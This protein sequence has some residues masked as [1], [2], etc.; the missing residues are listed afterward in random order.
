MSST[1]AV[2][3]ER[4]R[5]INPHSNA[6][7]LEI[8]T[9]LDWQCVVAKGAFKANDLCVYFPV[10]SILPAALE[11]HIFGPESKIRLTNS[12]IKTIKLRGQISQGLCV[13]VDEIHKYAWPCTNVHI[14]SSENWME[15]TD[16]TDIL[17]VTKYEPPAAPWSSMGDSSK[18]ARPKKN[19]LFAK[20]TDIE[21]AKNYP[22]M[23]KEGE[24][25]SVSEKCHGGNIR[26]AWAPVVAQTFLQ[27]LLKFFH[28]LPQY[29][30]VFGSHNVQLQSKNYTEK[31]IY[32]EMVKKYNLK[33]I[34]PKG[35]AVYG[36]VIGSG[37]QKNYTY[38]CKEGE[39]KLVLFDILCYN[40]KAHYLNPKK[41]KIL[42][43]QL[44]LETVPILYEGPFNKDKIKE[45][46]KGD[47][48]YAPSQKIREGVVVKPLEESTY[49]GSR[50]I[51]KFISDDYLLK[52]QSE[53][54]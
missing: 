49:L 41:F 27:K 22:E 12:R 18:S 48:V 8:A 50:K 9:I 40:G 36:E 28:L 13:P 11:E 45:L 26:M 20:Y 16:L 32:A 43:D 35:Y 37:V 54:H 24:M 53:Y 46:T 29:E 19:P 23:F 6:D 52:D 33:A 15:G 5:E 21:N 4:I 1:L 2:K 44:G 42:A 30:F 38:G 10:D 51:L 25:V 14:C 17:G 3:I 34:I 31:N 7:K 47:S 39:R